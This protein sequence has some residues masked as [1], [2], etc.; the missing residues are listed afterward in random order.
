LP[1]QDEELLASHPADLSSVGEVTAYRTTWLVSSRELL[2]SAGY[3]DRYLAALRRIDREELPGAEDALLSVVANNWIP[4][5]L[6]HAH[7]RACDAAGMSESELNAALITVDGG[8]VRRTW[9]AQIIAAAQRPDAETW[10][11]LSQV[12][13]WWP[14]GAQGGGMAVYRGG[15]K[16]ARFEYLGCSL[17]DIPYFRASTR[18]VLAVFLGRFCRELT[19]TVS[20]NPKQGH[21]S[22]TFRWR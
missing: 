7:Y 4:I 17:L 9:H 13:K 12:P 20:G 10:P 22:F 16:Q 19:C 2:R 11:L 8:Q 1:E 18:G 15:P 6:A 14:R 21:S 3:E 5:D